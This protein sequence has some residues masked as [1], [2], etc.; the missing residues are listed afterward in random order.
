MEF[1]N[2]QC[3]MG[4]DTWWF[5]CLY[6]TKK[7]EELCNSLKELLIKLYQSYNSGD[8]TNVVKTSCMVQTGGISESISSSSLDPFAQ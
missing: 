2:L 6:D 8:P 7:I 1:T 3:K 5:I 4:F